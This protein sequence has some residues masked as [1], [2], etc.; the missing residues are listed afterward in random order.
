M[1]RC[2]VR[3]VD[4]VTSRNTTEPV[5]GFVDKRINLVTRRYRNAA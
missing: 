2:T 5:S 1:R 4:C 3:D